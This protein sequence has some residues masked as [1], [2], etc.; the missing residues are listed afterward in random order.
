MNFLFTE[1]D[2]RW[3]REVRECINEMLPEEWTG[4]P[5]AA[6]PEK[7]TEESWAFAR[8]FNRKLYKK[9]WLT[10]AWPEE[11]GGQN[12][13]ATK[14]AIFR[15]ELAY[16]RAPLVDIYGPTIVGPTL[17]N[18]GSEEQKKEHLGRI[19]TGGVLW[20]QGFSEP[21]AG[22]D[23]ANL[24]TRAVKDG[25]YYVINGQKVWTSV[26]DRADWTFLLVRTG[27]P[28]LP[29]HKGLS[30]FLSELKGLEGWTPRPLE[31]IGG[32]R[33]FCEV[34]LDN[35]RIHK[36]NLVGGEN[37]GWYVAMASLDYERA[38]GAAFPAGYRRVLDDLVEYV[39]EKRKQG[40]VISHYAVVR[41]R[42]AELAVEIEAAKM[43]GYR[44]F[45]MLDQGNRPNYEAS[46]SHAYQ[47]D[48]GKR[49]FSVGM[50][51]L[52]LYGQL[53]M[54]SKAKRLKGMITRDYLYSVA[55]G[56]AGGSAEVM[57]NV[58]ATRGLNLPRD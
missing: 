11:Y 35:V 19:R 36:D 51:I 48:L 14:E 3:R 20:T 31:N 45:C 23:L 52:G 6:E 9:G 58:I 22:S 24:K 26:G 41:H 34:F 25:D 42:L 10:M 21:D 29:R 1:E 17:M 47:A 4:P 32:G 44:I 2:E 5:W 33:T 39:K 54:E 43:F 55:R 28:D 46:L 18:F 13:S 50:Q 56:L 16:A 15:E 12:A 8:E 38:G 49:L 53:G 30:L 37:K 40:E 27:G 7:D 57:R